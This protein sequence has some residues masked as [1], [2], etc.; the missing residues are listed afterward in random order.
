M[1][2]V[3]PAAIVPD[4][5]ELMQNYPN[6]FNPSTKISFAI[7]K[8]GNVKLIVY[9][10]NGKETVLLVNGRMNAGTHQITWNASGISSGVYFYKIETSDFTDVKKMI[11][12]K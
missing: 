10:I 4:K 3:D 12:V 6:P 5:Y 1:L 9:D 7:P 8:E 11:L 2:G